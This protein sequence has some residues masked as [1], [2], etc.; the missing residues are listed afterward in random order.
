MIEILATIMMVLVALWWSIRRLQR[1]FRAQLKS[2][3][4][5]AR[6][7]NRLYGW[8]WGNQSTNNYGYAP[9]TLTHPEKY[10]L[11]LYRALFAMA[12]NQTGTCPDILEVSCGRGGGLAQLVRERTGSINATG[13]DLSA[14]AIEAAQRTYGHIAN[15][16]FVRGSALALPFDDRSFDIVVN[17]EASHEYGDLDVFFAEVRRVL[18]P[19][20]LFLHCDSR[21]TIKA[22]AL[23]DAM[24]NAGF[25]GRTR[26]IT[27]NVSE[28]CRL[29]TSR[30]IRLLRSS[31]P[32]FERLLIGRWLENYAALEG[33]RK[34]EQF[35]SAE[36]RYYMS[37][38]TTKSLE[39]AEMVLPA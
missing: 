2:L 5:R 8:D 10:Q 7:W 25:V 14:C 1:R 18:K 37:C 9:A 32:W 39:S 19:A 13:L 34:F 24:A 15:L 12:D 22:P 31:V 36:R 27:E 3:D 21:T 23:F 6:L 29:D 33:S 28:A 26:D 30:R 11:E 20:G 35:R 4:G 17:V 16:T 38:L